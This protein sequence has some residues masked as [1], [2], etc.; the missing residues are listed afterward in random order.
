MNAVCLQAALRTAAPLIGAGIDR[1]AHAWFANKTNP[2]ELAARAR[3]RLE[4]LDTPA[5]APVHELLD[6]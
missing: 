5:A 6:P 3:I 2:L 1:I 4:L